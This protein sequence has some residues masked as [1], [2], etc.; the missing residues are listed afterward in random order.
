MPDPSDLLDLPKSFFVGIL[1]GLWWL[2]W[3]FCVEI[4]GWSIGWLVLRLITFGQ[5]PSEPLGG[6]DQASFG[7]ALFVEVVGLVALASAIWLLS[8]NWPQL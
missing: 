8:G 6:V 4:I 7:R 5:F 3:D 2:A 1:R